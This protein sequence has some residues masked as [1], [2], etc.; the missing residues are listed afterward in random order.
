[1]RHPEPL[2]VI[3]QNTNRGGPAAAEHKQ[4][5][6]EWIGLE[7]FPAQ[8][9]KSVDALPEINGLYR[10][11]H[12]HLGRDLNHSL[13]RQARSRWLQSTAELS[14]TRKISTQPRVCAGAGNNSRNCGRVSGRAAPLRR[15]RGWR[16]RW[17][18]HAPCDTGHA[19]RASS[20]A[21]VQRSSGNGDRRGWLLRHSANLPLN[22]RKSS[23]IGVFLRG[24]SES[25]IPAHAT[26]R[27]LAGS[28]RSCA[29]QDRRTPATG[30]RACGGFRFLGGYWR[31]QRRCPWIPVM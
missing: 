26:S 22:S 9:S 27:M 16:S 6:R 18:T 21:A 25:T 29:N 23:S 19:L 2:A 11:Q 24:I 14:G 30:L 28:S 8:M 4:P 10:H 1:M 7:L 12:V 3:N 31:D 17:V 20:T 13:C 5:S 15:L